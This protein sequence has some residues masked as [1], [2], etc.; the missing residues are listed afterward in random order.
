[1]HELS[2]HYRQPFLERPGGQAGQETALDH[3]LLIYVGGLFF[4]GDRLGRPRAYA[5]RMKRTGH[6]G[7]P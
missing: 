1:M 3:G 5:Y 4:V 2:L 7:N 6:E